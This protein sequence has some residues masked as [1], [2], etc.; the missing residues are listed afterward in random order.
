M[1]TLIPTAREDEELKACLFEVENLINRCFSINEKTEINL[2]KEHLK[3][4]SEGALDILR[5]FTPYLEGKGIFLDGN[6][7]LGYYFYK[8]ENYE[9]N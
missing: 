9:G 8:E 4:Y 7:K 1:D 3:S 6:H 5:A 2:K